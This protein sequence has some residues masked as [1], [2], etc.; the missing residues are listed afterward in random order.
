MR[1][2]NEGAST[3]WSRVEA[4]ARRDYLYPTLI[5]QLLHR[6]CAASVRT[7]SLSSVV[8]T[9]LLIPPPPL[10]STHP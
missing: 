9:A 8:L 1:K 5:T 4:A 6:L 2:W 10:A 3:Y 7:A